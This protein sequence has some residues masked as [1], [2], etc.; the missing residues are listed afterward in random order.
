MGDAYF[1]GLLMAGAI[2]GFVTQVTQIEH[3][4]GPGPII[5][6]FLC[7]LLIVSCIVNLSG[8]FIVEPNQAV[9]LI[10]FGRYRGTVKDPGFWWVNPF[11]SKRK[12]SLRVRNFD[13]QQLKVN[14]KKG[15]PIEISAVVVWR[16]RD[17]AQA[18]FDVE[19]YAEY[20][21]VQAESA[22]RR[23]ATEYPYDETDGEPVS[24][25]S[26]IDEVSHALGAEIEERVRAA[27]VSIDE[28]RIKH[29]TYAPEIAHAMLQRQ[30]A[31]AIIAARQKIVD[32]AVGMVEMA[33]HKLNEHQVVTLDEE[34]KAAMVSNLL[35]VLC[36][37]QRTQP[38]INAGTLY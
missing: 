2:Y 3:T 11:T 27:G 28:A 6:V 26:S 17:T 36:G 29:L 8:L 33:L 5:N 23:I 34:R 32:G 10:L 31:E 14:D 16:V 20:V 37:D 18:M 22:I 24:L 15:N 12:I 1:A 30:Q 9:V 13:S 21:H 4:D 7:V 38:I 19:D 25:L 35:V